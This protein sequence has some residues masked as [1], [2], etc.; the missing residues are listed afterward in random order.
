MAGLSNDKFW[1]D[2]EKLVGKLQTDGPLSFMLLD[3]GYRMQPLIRNKEI[4]FTDFLV[5][6]LDAK[7]CK[8]IINGNFYGL[9]LGGKSSVALGDPDDPSDTEIQGQIIM[10]GKVVAGDSRPQSF[11]FGQ[12]TAPIYEWKPSPWIYT[13]GKGDPPAEK[14]TLGAIGGLGPLLISNLRYGV[15][16][17]YSCA[18]PGVNEPETGE[19]SKAAMPCLI[20]RNNETFKSANAHDDETG[21]TILAFNPVTLMLLVLVQQHGAS[22]GRSLQQIAFD[23]YGRGFQSAVFLDGSD[24]ATMVVDGKIVISPGKRKNNSIDV[25]VGFFK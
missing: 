16:N 14:S 23:L 7:K 15:G 1:K 6:D 3:N 9:N 22:P 19:P 2:A 13:A 8:V 5:T 4:T 25:G 21:K 20:Q 18:P 24:S 10:A 12:I 17:K 11:W